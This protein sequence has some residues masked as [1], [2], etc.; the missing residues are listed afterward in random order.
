MTLDVREEVEELFAELSP[1][2]SDL[3]VHA[4]LGFGPQR[5]AAVRERVAEPEDIR[6]RGAETPLPPTY[7]GGP[8]PWAVDELVHAVAAHYGVSGDDIRGRRRYQP[9]AHARS[10][11]WRV[12]HD[13]RGMSLPW[14]G[15]M[16]DRDHSTVLSGV[17]AAR[18]RRG[19]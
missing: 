10:E 13:E 15:R 2:G 7:D 14:I 5:R 1:S 18:A 6:A 3:L 12:L 19:S 17:R 8:P 11:V 16:F 9:I 4:G